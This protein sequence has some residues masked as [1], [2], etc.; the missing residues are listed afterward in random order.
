LELFPGF[1]SDFYPQLCDSARLHIE[2]LKEHHDHPVI[3]SPAEL[4]DKRFFIERF[5]LGRSSIKTPRR[6]SL[7]KF[8][9]IQE[10][11]VCFVDA[12]SSSPCQPI[13]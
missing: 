13:N 8:R 1:L 4:G 12:K 3:T 2:I 5:D 9:L 11:T 7:S 6:Y 10:R